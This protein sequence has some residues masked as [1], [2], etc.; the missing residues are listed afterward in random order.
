MPGKP[1]SHD[2]AA[3]FG[4]KQ[5]IMFN[6]DSFANQYPNL[7]GYLTQVKFENGQVRVS[8]TLL[9]FSDGESVTLCLNDRH[10]NRTAFISGATMEGM[11]DDLEEGL[12]SGT[13]DW[14]TKGSKPTQ[15]GYTPF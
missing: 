1:I 8:S 6:D 11:M 14:K 3:G 4:R 7:T 2:P 15:N 13:L 5:T 10:N 9:I 12:D